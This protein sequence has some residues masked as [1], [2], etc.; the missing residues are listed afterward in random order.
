MVPRRA[1]A[2]YH[3][4]CGLYRTLQ[5]PIAVWRVCRPVPKVTSLF[6]LRF[7]LLVYGLAV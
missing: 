3:V 7:C 6:P 5:V 2:V 4:S 1:L